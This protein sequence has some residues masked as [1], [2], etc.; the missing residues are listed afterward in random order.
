[1]KKTLSSILVLLSLSA[2]T[3]GS[4]YTWEPLEDTFTGTEL[5]GNYL[6]APAMNLAWNQLKDY[7]LHAPIELN[8][9]DAETLDTIRRFND[10]PFTKNDLESKNYYI[11]VGYGQKTVDAINKESRKK[12]PDKSLE[13]LNLTLGDQDVIAYA[14]LNAA[15]E[16]LTAF[17]TDKIDFEG[18]RVQGFKADS[19][20]QRT[21]VAILD[22]TDNNEF[23]LSLALSQKKDRLYVIK[24]ME[25]STPEAVMNALNLKIT[26]EIPDSILTEGEY[27]AMPSVDVT[28][29]REYS[30]FLGL[31][32]LNPGFED[33]SIAQMF[34]NIR[35]HLDE[36]GA[37]VENEGVID[38][39]ATGVPDEKDRRFVMDK[40]FWIVMKKANSNMPYFLMQVKN[41]HFLVPVE[42]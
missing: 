19:E 17:S 1:M 21:N 3:S 35:F 40:P 20:N 18:T 16:Y 11:K 37:K 23:I 41:T 42:K 6:Y 4:T 38:L 10:S 36:T 9:E 26:D 7:V 13:D 27:F 2:C 12:F 33:Y 29:H 5:E 30:D 14:Y 28:A 15:V 24:G 39:V 25:D 8:T 32:V 31:G 22:Y 34:E